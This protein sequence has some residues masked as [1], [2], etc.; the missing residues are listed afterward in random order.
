MKTTDAIKQLSETEDL[1]KR[2]DIFI[3]W[4][5]AQNDTTKQ[6]FAL[7]WG[8]PHSIFNVACKFFN[9]SDIQGINWFRI[10]KNKSNYFTWSH[11][12]QIY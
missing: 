7:N 12:G 10:Y 3:Q 2:T 5:Q 1:E 11:G 4:L 6:R 8:I 9:A